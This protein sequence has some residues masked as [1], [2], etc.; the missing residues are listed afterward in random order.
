MKEEL[1]ML[2]TIERHLKKKIIPFWT[3]LL[4][5]EYDGFYGSVDTQSLQIKKHA[6]KGL[7]QQA[8]ML[9]SF[10]A[11]Q[12]HIKP[13]DYQPY[14]TSAFRY[15]MNSLK[16]INHLGYYWLSDYK[17]K[18]LD[19]RKITYG[20]GFVIYGL[21]EY[22]K[23]T[24]NQE[25]LNEAISLYR[26]IEEK[27]KNQDTLAYWEEFD[28]N[29]Q[30]T[31]CLILGDGVLNTTYTLNT[32]LHLLEAYMNLYDASKLEAVRQSVISLMEFFKN[33]LYDEKGKTLHAYLDADL[34]PLG[35][36]IS[37]G[38]NIEAAWLLDEACDIIQYHDAEI[39]KI[40]LSLVEQ[41]YHDGFFCRYV[42]NHRIDE[43]RDASIIWWVQSESMIGFYNQYQKTQ[44]YK[45]LHACEKIWET[46]NS[47]LVDPRE[48][49]E[50]FWSCDEN[51][52]PNYDR[53]EAELWKTPYHNSR[54]MIEL[55]ERMTLN[56]HTS[57][58]YRTSEPTQSIN[59]SKK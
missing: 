23:A 8:R 36:I 33:H 49:G 26:L 58:V 25:A 52:K 44:D 42:H 5:H 6:P 57:E 2:K 19:D 50:W 59:Q 40:T 35:N 30:K 9:W 29:W 38:H 24:K 39:K 22:Y 37:Y 20:Q 13:K 51:S 48:N 12:N 46:V 34:Q 18:I 3:K 45:Y 53:G 32:T 17:G 4:D 16:D 43:N 14:M 11:M 10:S 41:V 31:E 7:V 55:I 28:T 47:C 21:S 54:A 27:A 15:L 56:A 1:L